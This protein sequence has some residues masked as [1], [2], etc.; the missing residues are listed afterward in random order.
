MRATRTLILALIIFLLLVPVVVCRAVDGATARMI[1][2]IISTILFITTLFN[3]TKA[4]TVEL[5]IAGAT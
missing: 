1:V 3:L 4:R 5:F 2:I